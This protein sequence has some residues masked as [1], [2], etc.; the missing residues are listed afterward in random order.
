MPLATI[1]LVFGIIYAASVMRARIA[2][3]NGEARPQ[4]VLDELAEI[5]TRL[6]AIEKILKDVE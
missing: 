6:A 2:A 4:D 5:K 3:Q 1:L